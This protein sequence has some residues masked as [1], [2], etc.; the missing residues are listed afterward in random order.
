M[1]DKE[2]ASKRMAHYQQTRKGR[3]PIRVDTLLKKGQA[4]K[5]VQAIAGSAS[6]AG[7]AGTAIAKGS[8]AKGGEKAF[9][10]LPKARPRASSAE[11]GPVP[12]MKTKKGSVDLMIENDPLVQYL[13]KHA[14]SDKPPTAGLV[15]AEGILN[16]NGAEKMPASKP[17]PE[18]TSM[19]PCPTP[20]MEKEVKQSWQPYLDQ[21]FENREG[22]TRKYKDKDHDPSTADEGSGDVQ[23]V[24]G[25]R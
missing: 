15:D 11:V 12:G 6:T 3:R 25:R 23:R 9:S 22:I 1:M 13:K 14:A 5:A 8:V 17:E 20:R 24:L 7:K 2:S 10:T 16:D 19:C 18:V 4:I 21:M